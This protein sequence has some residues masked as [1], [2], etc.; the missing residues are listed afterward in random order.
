MFKEFGMSWDDFT[1][2]EIEKMT[3]K[4][5]IIWGEE[6]TICPVDMGVWYNSHLPNS[7]FIKLPEIGHNPHF[8]C[9][10]KCIEAL[11]TWQN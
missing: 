9:P 4:T 8:E 3:T 1:S 5:L 2:T 7:T 11:F 6:D 10:E